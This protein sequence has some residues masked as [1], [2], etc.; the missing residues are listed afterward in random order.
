MN[1][2]EAGNLAAERH[3]SAK[4]DDLVRRLSTFNSAIVAFSGG[5][6]S[7]F[8]AYCAHLVYETRMLAVTVVSEFETDEMIDFA[9]GFTGNHGIPHKLIY[10][11]N[12]ENPAIRSNPPERCYHCK[13]SILGG[14][15]KIA[16]EEGYDVVFD[17]QNAD[18][19]N[20]YRPGMKAV[21][22]TGTLSPL[23]TASLTKAE[24]R[25]LSHAFGL[26][27]W[28][29]PSSPCLASRIPY[30]TEI[31]LAVIKQIAA[32]EKYLHEKG[33]AVVRVR[34]HGDLARIEIDPDQ[35]AQ[36]IQYNTETEQF[37]RTL[38]FKYVTLDLHGYRQGS[39]NEGIK[40]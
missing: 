34:V 14:L 36:F 18:D 7:S 40:A 8:L 3:L 20:D 2:N 9:R 37:F 25:T 15:W 13:L 22:E 39:L 24:I 31:N 30:G 28:D 35:Q 5:V 21:Q 29:H 17:G 6:D 33:F 23:L 38:G 10:R 4:W 11:N 32:G 12:L 1:Q 26:E 16:R 19:L 27:T